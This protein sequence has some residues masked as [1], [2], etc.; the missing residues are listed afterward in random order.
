MRRQMA[1]LG[2]SSRRDN[3]TGRNSG[4]RLGVPPRGT[5]SSPT[6]GLCW[7]IGSL[8]DPRDG[9]A[10][11]DRLISP[12][13]Q[14]SKQPFRARLQLFARLTP[15]ARN[16]AANKPARVAQLDDGNDRAILV[17]GDEGSAQ[18]IRLG[19][20]GALTA[21]H[22]EEDDPQERVLFLVAPASGGAGLRIVRGE[23]AIGRGSRAANLYAVGPFGTYRAAAR[24]CLALGNS[25]VI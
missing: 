7:A 18:V 17:Q 24:K 23:L 2:S 20:R 5:A 14:Q 12:A 11:P 10:G 8:S 6:S 1:P 15:N 16:N 13:M 21:E 19:H 25:A 9:A 3:P 22:A 4:G